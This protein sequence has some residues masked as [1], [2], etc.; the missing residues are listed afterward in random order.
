[1]ADSTLDPENTPTP[2]RQLGKGHGTDALGPSGISDTGS[3]VMGNSGMVVPDDDSAVDATMVGQDDDLHAGVGA[4]PDVGDAN[5]DSDSDEHGTGERAAAGR[6]S[7]AVPGSDIAAD[8]VVNAGEMGTTDGLDE[9]EMANVDPVF[10]NTR[11]DK[12]GR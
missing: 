2:D 6:D 5:L 9:A 8:Q 1:M 11:R 10:P 7:S 12:P 4:G 3:D